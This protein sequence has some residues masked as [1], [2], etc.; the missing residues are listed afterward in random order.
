MSRQSQTASSAIKRLALIRVVFF[1]FIGLLILRL[2][3]LQVGERSFYEALASGQHDLLSQLLPERG[4]ILVQ[5]PL[6][7]KL[8]PVATNVTLK[9]VYAVPKEISD[10]TKT[11]LA[12]A[13]LLQME[14]ADLEAKLSKSDDPYEPLKNALGPELSQQIA[15]LKLAGIYL[16][17]ELVRYYL[18]N[19][20]YGQLLGF[21][22]FVGEKRR[23]QYGLEQ[24]WEE[25]L[26]GKQGELRAEKQAGGGIIALGE[27]QVIP[28]VDGADIILT[29]D[30]NIQSRACAAVRRAVEKHG[31]LSGSVV[32]L[33][34][35]TGA[36]R[37]MC[38]WPN[39][40]PNAYNKVTD[41]SIYRNQV[42][43]DA[44]EPGSVFKPITLAAALEAKAVTPETTY[45]DTGEVK[46]GPHT[47]R[48]SDLKA[49]G[50]QTMTEVLQK[51]LNTGAIYALRRAG[52]EK[53][54][55]TVYAFGFG[56]L[57]GIELPHEKPGNL[58]SLDE[59]NEIYAATASFGQGITVTSLQLAAAFS[60]IAN[61]G[62][63]LKPYLVSEVRYSDGRRQL[64]TPV[65]VGQ[66]I[67]PETASTLAAMMVQVVEKGHG[68]RA[69]VPGYYVAGKT[70]TAQ[71]PY[72]DK[73]GYDPNKT[74]GSFVGFAPVSAPK[75]VIAVRI[76]E[77]QGLV[78]AESSAAPVFGELAKFLLEY[79]Q[80]PPERTID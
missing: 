20:D 38:G 72:Q 69:A 2:Y 12:L 44:Y 15:D 24:Y 25:V 61:H 58:S 13:P 9:Q 32:V 50:I 37:A 41:V 54:R 34:P 1:V 57:T 79:Y 19:E 26:A 27:R 60:A 64:T 47:I 52:V 66:P 75:F 11:A 63:L 8:Y 80:V 7:D 36:V 14:P 45:M 6:S 71:V 3:E 62:R 49:N 73:A 77:P 55:Q 16:G 67:S 17:P 65:T 29:I 56:K 42:V 46:I 68:K 40:D 33:D 21:M 74:I 35:T 30:K 78:F 10:P 43:S 53:F 18:G 59:K 70:G 28:A 39:F 4:E 76:N 31:A 48:N 51:S 23:G 22:G 5:D